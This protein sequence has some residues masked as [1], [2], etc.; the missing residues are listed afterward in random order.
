MCHGEPPL[1]MYLHQAMKEQDRQQFR[2]DMDK[3]VEDQI[4]NNNFMI[5]SW[6]SV[7]EK[8]PVIPTVWQMKRKR[9]IVTRHGKQLNID[10]SKMIKGVHYHK[11]YSLV[12][13]W[14]SIRTMLILAAQHS[15]HMVQID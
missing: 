13:T 4:E 12:A 5:V 14:N 2:E 3:E 9:D 15:W 1:Q 6:R 7:P 8:E 11:S 10:G